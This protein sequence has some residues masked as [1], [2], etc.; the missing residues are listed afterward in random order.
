M[1]QINKRRWYSPTEKIDRL[2]RLVERLMANE[3]KNEREINVIQNRIPS[4]PITPPEPSDF[5]SQTPSFSWTSPSTGIVRVA[6]SDLVG[7]DNIHINLTPLPPDSPLI[8]TRYS[9]NPF[10]LF[11]PS[12]VSY[13]LRIRGQDENN[14][15]SNWSRTQSVKSI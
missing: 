9:S 3:T 8:P 11:L 4:V 13:K 12:G 5:T 10:T 15:F 7:W 1:V 14:D 2:E 6:V